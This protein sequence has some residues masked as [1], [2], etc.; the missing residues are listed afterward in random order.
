MAVAGIVCDSLIAPK[1]KVLQVVRSL[2]FGLWS[3]VFG[4]VLVLGPLFLVVKSVFSC[5]VPS[6]GKSRSSQDSIAKNKAPRTKNKTKDQRPKT[7][8]LCF[9]TVAVLKSP[10]N[11]SRMPP[12]LPKLAANQNS[13]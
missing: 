11:I 8:D 12:F 2:V 7:H 9:P 6:E 5:L 10:Q 1:S 4:F 13:R 3:L